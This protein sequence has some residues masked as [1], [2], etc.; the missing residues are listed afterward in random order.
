MGKIASEKSNWGIIT[1][2][3]P[4]YESL[5]VITSQIFV[6]ISSDLKKNWTIINDRENAI[7][8]AIKQAKDQDIILVAGKGHESTQEINGNFINFSD[9]EVVTRILSGSK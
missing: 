5:E 4:R 2:D 7:A 8:T 9:R 1:A 6:G 3:N